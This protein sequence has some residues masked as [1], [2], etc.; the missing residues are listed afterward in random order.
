MKDRE[1]GRIILRL[2]KRKYVARVGVNVN[3]STLTGFIIR[4]LE[5]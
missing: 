4:D 2:I 1:G 3:S 5:P